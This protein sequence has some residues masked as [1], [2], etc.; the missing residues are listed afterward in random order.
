MS[1]PRI[2]LISYLFPPMGGIGVQR[3][4]SI[5]RY[6]PG[7]GFELHVLRAPNAAGPVMDPALVNLVPEDV[8]V[9]SAFTPEIPFSLRQKAWQW[10]NRAKRKPATPA[11]APVVSKR[12]PLLGRII[13]KVLAPEPEILWVPFALRAAKRIIRRHK[14]DAVIVTAPPFSAFVVGNRLKRIFP[15]VK[16]IADFRDEWLEF[17]INNNA[18]QNNPYARKRAVEIERETIERADA[19]ISVTDMSLAT[20]RKR[21]PEQPDAKFHRIANGYDPAA[22]TGFKARENE[23]A[24]LIVTHMGTAYL[25]SSP[26]YYA[27]ALNGLPEEVRDG[28]VTRFVGRV[29]DA[30]KELLQNAKS[31]IQLLGFMP[32]Q[33]AL[34]YLEDT[35]Y[36]LMTMTDK[37]SMPGKAYE[38]LATG[39]PFLTIAAGDS[40][41]G[42]FI[43]QTGAGYCA[44]PND[45]EE[46][47][48]MILKAFEGKKQRL[49]PPAP[50][51]SVVAQY[52]RPQLVQ[53]FADLLNKMVAH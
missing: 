47:R 40:E 7:M 16:F 5:A 36:V 12:Q 31:E 37:I 46:I 10:L 45:V 15:Q 14:I 53:Q 28:I 18:F 9:H 38:Y 51:A 3:A 22:F 23:T 34:G 4:L 1:R 26:R 50:A 11:P 20:I 30:E 8:Q 42:N 52:A 33:K 17:Y 32:Q 29:E 43:R 48:A 39:K 13:R 6:L 49:T 24:K 41:V 35:D 19:V 27:A 44:D 25:N 21:Y 2:L